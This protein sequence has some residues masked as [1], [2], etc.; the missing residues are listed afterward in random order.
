MIT[1]W[2]A[3]CGDDRFVIDNDIEVRTCGRNWVGNSKV[4]QDLALSEQ[5]PS[6]MGRRNNKRNRSQ[7]GVADSGSFLYCTFEV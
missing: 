2:Q 7:D 1:G 4:V 5:D 6:W 3:A